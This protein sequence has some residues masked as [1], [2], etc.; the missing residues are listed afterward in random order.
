MAFS[1]SRVAKCVRC[2]ETYGLSSD[3]TIDQSTESVPDRGLPGSDPGLALGG[4]VAR[5]VDATITGS[6]ASSADLS[7]HARHLS[8][9]PL[10]TRQA[11]RAR[12]RP[13]GSDREA[14]RGPA[15]R[16]RLPDAARRHRFGQD[17]HDGERDRADRPPGVRAGAEQDAGGAALLRVPRVLPE[18]RGRVLRLLL[19]LLPARGLRSVARP[20]HREGLLDQRAHRADAAVGDQGAPRAA[21]TA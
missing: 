13:A 9:Q 3:C 8:E 14:D 20:V 10:R 19:R 18:Q 1:D 21:A 2:A 16:P 5:R 4:R 12:R 6:P 15:G 11:V 7:T 17:V